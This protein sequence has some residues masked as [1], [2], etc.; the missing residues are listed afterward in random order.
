MGEVP[1]EPWKQAG[2]AGIK[3]SHPCLLEEDGGSYVLVSLTL[4]TAVVM[5][6]ILGT[7]CRDRKE[8][9]AG[10]GWGSAEGGKCPCLEGG[11]L[12]RGEG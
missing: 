5:E 3:K 8:R 11:F 1:S 10:R 9:G 7:I 12:G 6:L 4:V 2:T